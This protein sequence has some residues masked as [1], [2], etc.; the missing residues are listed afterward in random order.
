MTVKEPP[1]FSVIPFKKDKIASITVKTGNFLSLKILEMEDGFAG[2]YQVDEAIPVAYRKTWKDGDQSPGI[3]L[4]T[5]F[6][7]KQSIDYETFIRRWHLGHTPLSLK[8]HPL[9]NYNR[10]LVKKRLTGSSE[11]WDG[12]VEEHFKSANDLLNPA[13]FFG[14]PLLMFYRML[15]VYIDTRSFLDYRTIQTYLAMEYHIKSILTKS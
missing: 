13:R 10:N 2:A 9:W 14:G 12:I 5:I 8:I 15:Q 11:T 6:R 1:I 7:K 4:L 3:N